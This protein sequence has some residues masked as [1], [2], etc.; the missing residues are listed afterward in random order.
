MKKLLV[1]ATAI[2]FTASISAFA[3]GTNPKAGHSKQINYQ[4]PFKKI[5]VSN[6][7]DLVL[8][9]NVNKSLNVSGLAQ[10]IEN[11]DW[12]I[13]NNVLYLK[14]KKGSLKDKV[15]VTLSVTQLKE[16]VVKGESAVSSAGHLASPTLYIFIENDSYVS[17]RNFGQIYVNNTPDTELEIKKIVGEVII[18]K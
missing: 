12:K 2:L 17:I 7:I 16:I 3:S 5:V 10:D 4:I 18:G 6:D 13:K 8:H 14:S 15:K 1:M 11:V 9:E